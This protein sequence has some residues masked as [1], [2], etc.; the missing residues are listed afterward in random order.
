MSD[1]R[2]MIDP[3]MNYLDEV[4]ERLDFFY[5]DW[6]VLFWSTT[7]EAIDKLRALQWEPKLPFSI[8]SF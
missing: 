3:M 5:E 6:M 1:P 2:D 7:E 8:A 4:T